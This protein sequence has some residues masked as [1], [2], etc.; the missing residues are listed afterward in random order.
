MRLIALRNDKEFAPYRPNETAAAFYLSGNQRGYIV[1]RNIRPKAAQYLAA[2][3][4]GT[5][6]SKLSLRGGDRQVAAAHFERAAKAGSGSPKL[7]FDLA[8][9][10]WESER[11]SPRVVD[12]LKKVVQLDTNF[13]DG[14]WQL[15]MAALNARD[16]QTAGIALAR[17]PL[18]D[19]RTRVSECS[20][21]WRACRG[22]PAGSRM[23]ER[24]RP[25]PASSRNR[26]RNWT[27][28]PGS[29]ERSATS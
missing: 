19:A 17:I 8:M 23:P 13:P 6:S 9:L 22:K 1:M 11:G 2:A 12:L 16:C 21:G 15:A 28:S 5:H 29:C 10:T 4:A 26:R 7:Y 20:K 3:G 24:A 25:A 18:G 14:H 27:T